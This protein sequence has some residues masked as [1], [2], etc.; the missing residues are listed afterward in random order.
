M[1]AQGAAAAGE[2]A[3]EVAAV[4]VAAVG[5]APGAGAPGAGAPWP[6][7]LLLLLL[8]AEH[9]TPAEASITHGQSME[10]HGCE[11]ARV[12]QCHQQICTCL[13]SQHRP[14]YATAHKQSQ[15]PHRCV[16][17]RGCCELHLPGV[18]V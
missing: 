6:Q 8:I 5:V 14:D 9:L 1:A 18:A 13:E 15:A 12:S 11:P 17:L 3:V 16:Q 4:G 10:W 7:L 2:A